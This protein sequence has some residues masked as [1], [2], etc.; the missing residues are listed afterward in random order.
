MHRTNNQRDRQR[1]NQ[2]QESDKLY[3]LLGLV[4]R[5]NVRF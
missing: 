3:A 1:N 2:E 4:G 5:P